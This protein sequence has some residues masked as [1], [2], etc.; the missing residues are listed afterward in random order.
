MLIQFILLLIVHWLADFVCQTHWQA[1]NKSKSNNALS[2]H[3]LTYTWVLGTTSFFI[4]EGWRAHNGLAWLG[5]VWLNA[6]LHFA[7]DWCT[8]RI[9]S[10]LFMEQFEVFRLVTQ[11]DLKSVKPATE[12]RL[13]MKKD[14]NP[15]NFFVVI[16]LD[17]LIHQVTLA[18]TMVLFFGN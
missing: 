9:T 7:T 15:H 16:G 4:F 2:R 10:R 18:G 5:F 17:Q 3:V 12:A 8:S 14:F 6:A 1:S 13:L 11:V